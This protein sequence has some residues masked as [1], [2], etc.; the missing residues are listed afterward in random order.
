MIKNIKVL[1]VISLLLGVA[2]CT[3]GDPYATVKVNKAPSTSATPSVPKPIDTKVPEIPKIPGDTEST[4][5]TESTRDTKSTR[6][7][8]VPTTTTSTPATETEKFDATDQK[9][10]DFIDQKVYEDAA[11]IKKI[12]VESIQKLQDEKNIRMTKREFLARTYQIIRD[13]NMTSFYL[14]VARLLNEIK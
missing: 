3:S 10:V 4:R 9:I 8:K 6:T 7:P 1:A 11:Q 2:S 14:A 13:N 12:T 5:N